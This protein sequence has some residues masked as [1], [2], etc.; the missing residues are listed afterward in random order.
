[1][2]RALT[3]RKKHVRP[4]KKHLRLRNVFFKMSESKHSDSEF[5]C[6]GEPLGAE[7][8]QLP[9]RTEATESKLKQV[10]AS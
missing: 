6:S 2:T 5:S 10:E 7:I 9:T 4:Y 3:S 8:L 1:M